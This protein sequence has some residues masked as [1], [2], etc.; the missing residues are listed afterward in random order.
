MKLHKGQRVRIKTF[1]K[2]PHSWNDEGYMDRFMGKV[3]IIKDPDKV[4]IEGDRRGWIFEP[5]DFEPT[6]VGKGKK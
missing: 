4:G 6:N 1:K 2:R 5:T 3:V